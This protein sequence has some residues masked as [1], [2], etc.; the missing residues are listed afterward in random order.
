MSANLLQAIRRVEEIVADAAVHGESVFTCEAIRA[1]REE[2]PDCPLSSADLTNLTM[3]ISAECGV[4]VRIE[5]PIEVL[6]DE[7]EASLPRR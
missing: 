1:V 3:S 5:T 4:P 6:W 7:A 2:H